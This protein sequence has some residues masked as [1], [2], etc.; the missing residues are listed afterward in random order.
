MSFERAL[1]IF[2]RW[3]A[4]SLLVVH[5]GHRVLRS[6]V[7][8]GFITQEVTKQLNLLGG[9]TL[10]VL[11]WEA[12]AKRGGDHSVAQFRFAIVTWA[13]MAAML[14]LLFLL[15]PHMDALLDAEN[16]TVI[17]DERFYRWHGWYLIV[18]TVQWLAGWAHLTAGCMRRSPGGL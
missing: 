10:A 4:I 8:Q 7:R 1:R 15:H 5:T 2:R 3:L 17:D 9:V 13:I 18:S 16:R 11:L 14:V 12:L 6:K